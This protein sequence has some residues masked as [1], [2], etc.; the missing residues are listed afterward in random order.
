MRLGQISQ[1]AVSNG[2]RGTFPTRNVER[3]I[4]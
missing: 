1:L 3:G 2:E 4:W